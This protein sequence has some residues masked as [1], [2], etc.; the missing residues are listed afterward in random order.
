MACGGNKFSVLFTTWAGIGGNARDALQLSAKGWK[1]TPETDKQSYTCTLLNRA[2]RQAGNG[3]GEH[4]DGTKHQNT[5]LL[6]IN[7]W[8]F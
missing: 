2:G 7:Y 4:N 6:C 8:I 5:E 3:G 1:A